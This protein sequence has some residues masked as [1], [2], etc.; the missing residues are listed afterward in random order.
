MSLLK[1]QR[2]ALSVVIGIF[3]GRIDLGHFAND[4]YRSCTDEEE[5]ET[6]PHLLRACWALFQ[7]RRKYLDACYKDDLQDLNR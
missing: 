6:V 1:L 4:F 2:G 3:E 7:R 5:E